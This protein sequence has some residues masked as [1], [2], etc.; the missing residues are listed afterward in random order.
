VP[1]HSISTAASTCPSPLK[2]PGNRFG[3]HAGVRVR[4]SSAISGMTGASCHPLQSAS[5]PARTPGGG[6]MSA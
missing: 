3:G 5:R 2:S 6:A 4:I 1:L